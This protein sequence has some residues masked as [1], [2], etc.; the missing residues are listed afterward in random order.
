MAGHVRFGVLFD[1]PHIVAHAPPILTAAGVANR[2]RIQAG[3]FLKQ[4]LPVAAPMY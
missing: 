4:C 2:C 1:L 3:T